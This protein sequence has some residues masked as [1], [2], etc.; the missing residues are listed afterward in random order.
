[1]KIVITGHKHGLGEALYDKLTVYNRTDNNNV[2]GFDIEDGYD[3]G[4]KN[5]LGKILYQSKDADIF[6]NNAYHPSGQTEL[7]S[8]LLKLWNHKN[9]IIIHIGTYLVYHDSQQDLEI[10]R[11]YIQDK[12]YQKQLIDLH[13]KTDSTLK[14]LQANPGL[15][16]TNFLDVM[17]VP[18]SPNLLNVLDCA[19]AILYN[20]NMLSKGI[21]I[22]E[23]TLDNL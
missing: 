23:I 20:V 16:K 18:E 12:K 3:I 21:Y 4:N 10:H 1:M 9:K 17:K 6:I 8:Q 19:D 15:M 5:T 2:I 11:S 13:R 22:K 14:V 7:L